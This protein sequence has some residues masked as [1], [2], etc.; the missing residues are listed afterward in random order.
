MGGTFAIQTEPILEQILKP[1]II[2]P[3]DSRFP[4][5][6]VVIVDG[7]QSVSSCA[8]LMKEH[9]TTAVLISDNVGRIDGIFTDRDLFL[10]MNLPEGVNWEVPVRTLMSH[11]VM[12]LAPDVIH[13]APE[14]MATK[15][16]RH[17]PIAV[18]ESSKY[19]V[20][21]L[22]TMDAIFT[23]NVNSMKVWRDYGVHE[24]ITGTLGI[25]TDD[26]ALSH[27]IEQ[28]LE[29]NPSVSIRTVR[30]GEVVTLGQMQVLGDSVPNLVIDA[31]G[32]EDKKLVKILHTLM[33]KCQMQRIILILSKD[34]L[35][36]ALFDALK[37][38]QDKAPLHILFKPL[39]PKDLIA[40]FQNQ[41]KE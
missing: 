36:P 10:K 31:D 25:L 12:T 16:I 38:L 6:P 18:E 26:R 20:L 41:K 9:G 13:L 22:L 40:A 32:F 30:R 21:G 34:A 8:E 23:G 17:V 33:S 14:L 7:G 2:Q 27:R 28:L 19:R 3:S 11:P 1:E 4:L 15:G 35:P 29:K 37:K 24:S 39:E 5:L